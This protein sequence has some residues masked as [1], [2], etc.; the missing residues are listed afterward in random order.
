MS[1]LFLLPTLAYGI[2]LGLN[3]GLWHLSIIG[4]LTLV[5]WVLVRSRKA[6]QENQEIDIGIAGV[7][8]GGRRLSGFS[9]FWPTWLNLKLLR[10]MENPPAQVY[11][12][13][14]LEHSE[15]LK[16]G[17]DY[18]GQPVALEPMHTL[19]IG[20][21]GSGKTEFL[22][23]MIE[24]WPHRILAIDFKGGLGFSKA[25]GIER[26]V[27]N[28]SE[29]LA[30]FLE[31]AQDELSA[32]ELRLSRGE[33]LRPVMLLVDEFASVVKESPQAAQ[34]FESIAS[35]GRAL[36]F[37]LFVASQTLSGVS[38]TVLAN[39]LQRVG[40]GAIDQVDAMQLGLS[41]HKRPAFGEG[42][43]TAQ[44]AEAN[45]YFS[46]PL[47]QSQISRISQAK[48]VGFSDSRVV[49][50]SRVRVQSQAQ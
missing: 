32:R 45:F 36:E 18:E 13:R 15:V 27:T 38:R 16:V 10:T 23:N 2:F 37:Y 40:L 46:F 34:L 41:K 33:K 17:I 7:A 44:L 31:S 14:Y 49:D 48:T 8:V 19:I 35:K 43:S 9:I 25:F 5:V 26:L 29:N 22:R 1:I 28:H 21:T 12:E 4:G 47:G 11:L 20:P 42:W 50:L 30:E 39:C 3:Q 24:F 6:P